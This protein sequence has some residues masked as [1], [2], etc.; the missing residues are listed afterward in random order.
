M[1]VSSDQ[2]V[3]GVIDVGAPRNIGWAVL[4]GNQLKT[5]NDLDEFIEFFAEMAKDRPAALGFEA[6]MFVPLRDEL[7]NITKQRDGEK[8]RPWSAG[9]GATVTTIGLAVMGY[10]LTKLK[11]RIPDKPATLD[12]HTW[13]KGNE[14]LL[15]EAFVSGVNHAGPGEH[16][17]DALTAAK[18]LVDA[19][20]DLD[21]HNAVTGDNVFSL[22][23]AT[24]AR[25][26]WSTPS[27]ELLA[28]PCLVIRPEES[29]ELCP[30]RFTCFNA[31]T[32]ATKNTSE[33]DM[34]WIQTA[35][36]KKF[37]IL[38]PDVDQ[39]DID[40]IAHA[41][42]MLCRF[43]GHCTKFYSV[44]EH[45]VH[46]SREVEPELALVGLLH[47]AAEA[48]L[49]DIP[50]PL[51]RLLPNFKEFEDRM[52]EAIGTKFG[53]D[54]NLFKGTELKRADTQLL[55]DEKEALMVD[56]PEPWP[57]NA[58]VAASISE[59]RTR[60]RSPNGL[61]VGIRPELAARRSVDTGMLR[62]LP[63]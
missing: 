1:P 31:P 45:S 15:F 47:D 42:S 7:Q 6:P 13:P 56:A 36:G 61:C 26:G 14:M 9:A 5:G 33:G 54:A 58:P 62:C 63:A 39:I 35:S 48:Y 32:T 40:D 21:A 44:A 43:N 19:Y 24:L 57:A 10:T 38:E 52:E 22:V 11:E 53:I 46:V 12:W 20:P 37:S 60:M 23:G 49:G 4:L 29:A 18:G 28:H 51:K 25:T 34:G 30:D 59:R 8:G 17:R 27:V 55:V 2:I 16:W 50:T 3:V 41:L